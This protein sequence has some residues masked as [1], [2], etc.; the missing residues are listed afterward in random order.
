MTKLFKR[1]HNNDRGMIFVTVLMII[2]MM[3]T[4]TATMVSLNVTSIKVSEA[5]YR[6][7]QAQEL[8]KG[9]IYYH[10][11]NQQSA[12]P[13]NTYTLNHTID[14]MPFTTD[15]SMNPAGAGTYGTNALSIATSY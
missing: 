7:I 10:A 8:T 5:E 13:T 11:A 15:V 1:L 6:H 3:M 9:L 14:G 2:T 4:L 12:T